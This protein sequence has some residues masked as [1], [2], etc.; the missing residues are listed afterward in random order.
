MSCDDG[1]VTQK[2]IDEIPLNHLSMTRVNKRI[3]KTSLNSASYATH[4]QLSDHSVKTAFI[5]LN[6]FEGTSSVSRYRSGADWEP[7]GRRL[8]NSTY[9]TE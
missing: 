2:Y 8:G 4:K 5:L 9:K 1:V 3:T 7:V 6:S